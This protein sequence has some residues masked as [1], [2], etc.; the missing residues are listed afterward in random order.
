MR[1]V[2]S[3]AKRNCIRSGKPDPGK[4]AA[5]S[6]LLFE[7]YPRLLDIG[8]MGRC[9]TGMSGNCINS[10]IQ[11]YQDGL[12]RSE[13]NMSFR[14]Y[15]RIIDESAGKTF[16]VSL[17]GRGD[18]DRHRNFGDMLIYARGRGIVANYSTSGFYLNSEIV[19]LSKMY[20]GTVAVSFHNQFYTYRAVKMLLAAG[21]KTNI[22]FVLSAASIDDAVRRLENNGF[23]E[24]LNAVVFLL[25]K[26]VGL[27]SRQN[28]LAV[29]DERL[30][31]FFKII[32]WKHFDFK[33]GFDT[34]SVP[35][36]INF[37]DQIGRAVIDPCMGARWSA[38]ISP[39]MEMMPCSFCVDCASWFYDISEDT[40]ENAWRS[41]PFDRFRGILAERCPECGQRRDCLGGCPVKPEIVL[42][43]R[44][45]RE[46]V[47]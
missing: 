47:H 20:C 22:H 34:C 39:K 3:T 32:G 19:R 9:D 37:T 7:S 15:K 44:K 24:G 18:P 46:Y 45:E 2:L 33:I 13:P 1:L 43:G 36:I 17:G 23:P 8:I 4:G 28:I 11:C 35:G 10:G 29:E 5:E 21:I 27:G 6:D 30:R 31:K 25:H 38:Y 26:P 41:E 42:C 12:H 40:I 16:L 14:N